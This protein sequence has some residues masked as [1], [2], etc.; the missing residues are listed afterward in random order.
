MPTTQCHTP[1]PTDSFSYIT[2]IR[3][4]D[5]TLGAQR[6]LSRI[7]HLCDRDHDGGLEGL[8]SVSPL[9]HLKQSSWPDVYLADTQVS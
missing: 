3:V 5:L 6:A 7:F 2:S 8:L 1:I 9:I 4:H